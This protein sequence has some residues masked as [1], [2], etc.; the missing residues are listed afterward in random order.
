M[1]GFFIC[2]IP[3]ASSMNIT[4]FIF[5][6]HQKLKSSM[7]RIYQLFLLVLINSTSLFGQDNDPRGGSVIIG[8]QTWSSRNL[9]VHHFINGDPIP[10]A[11]TAR[12]WKDASNN[13]TPA[14]CYFENN[15]ANDSTYGKLYNWYA[16]IDPRGLAPKGWHVP[17]KTEWELIESYFGG[18]KVAAPGLKTALGWDKKSGNKTQIGGLMGGGRLTNGRFFN[19]G[20]IGDWWSSTP[21]RTSP[22]RAYA[23]SLD[24]C[25]ELV[26]LI[27]VPKGGGASVRCVKD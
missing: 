10:E 13:H 22:R 16:V 2:S 15:S 5:Q 1:P 7:K 8:T 19:I 18:Y 6:Q 12:E 26:L 20:K 14:W 9:N 23:Y 24:C 21:D 11:R 3:A 4:S 17:S 25:D 27:D